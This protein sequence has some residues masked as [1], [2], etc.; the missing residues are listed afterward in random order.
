MHLQLRTLHHILLNWNV[1]IPWPSREPMCPCFNHGI[2][3]EFW[4][5]GVQDNCS[6]D[7]CRDPS[8]VLKQTAEKW[9]SSLLPF[10]PEN[11]GILSHCPSFESF[12]PYLESTRWTMT[13]G[14]NRGGNAEPTKFPEL[15]GN[16]GRAAGERAEIKRGSH[17]WSFPQTRLFGNGSEKMWLELQFKS[18]KAQTLFNLLLS[19]SVWAFLTKCWKNKLKKTT[20]GGKNILFYPREAALWL[21]SFLIPWLVEK[22]ISKEQMSKSIAVCFDVSGILKHNTREILV[23]M[24]SFSKG[25]FPPAK[26]RGVWLQPASRGQ[27]RGFE[28]HL[29]AVSSQRVVFFCN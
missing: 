11:R 16:N 18:F 10:A 29:E 25:F 5:V 23:H 6:L 19:T 17:I 2:L 28:L 20:S 24:K 14:N 27:H 8:G 7:G 15:N 3:K 21:Q 12:K 4:E 26:R 22:L 13:E 1:V 9:L